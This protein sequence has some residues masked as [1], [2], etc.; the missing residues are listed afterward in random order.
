M[1][2]CTSPHLTGV[3]VCWHTTRRLQHCC[4]VISYQFLTVNNTCS[5][6]TKQ[7]GLIWQ[8]KKAVKLC[9]Y[10]NKNYIG[11]FVCIC[12]SNKP[13]ANQLKM[14]E[15][16]HC[17]AHLLLPFVHVAS[18]PAMELCTVDFARKACPASHWKCSLEVIRAWSA[19]IT[20]PTFKC[21]ELS[22]RPSEKLRDFSFYQ[23]L[24]NF[25]S[26]SVTWR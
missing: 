9:G 26:L 4:V 17:V 14:T 16:A 11:L 24:K 19:S 18:V 2:V 23:N 6:H 12:L 7:F 8:Q 1:L 10:I 15:W 3:F 13:S 20:F 25:G 5:C 22:V 21:C